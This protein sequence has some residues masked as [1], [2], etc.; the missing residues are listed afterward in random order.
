VT[1]DTTKKPKA[2]ASSVQPVRPKKAAQDLDQIPSARDKAGPSHE[3][4]Q[5]QAYFVAERRIAMGLP[6]DEASDWAE[7]ERQL[8]ASA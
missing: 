2:K 8:R 4:I 7:A 6:G 5:M 3:E 1:A